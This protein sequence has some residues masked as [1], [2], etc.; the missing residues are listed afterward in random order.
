MSALAFAPA[1]LPLRD[2]TPLP[3]RDCTPRRSRALSHAPARMVVAAPQASRPKAAASRAAAPNR[4]RST[5]LDDNHLYSYLRDIGTI[6]LLSDDEVATCSAHIANLSRWERVKEQLD[7]TAA[8]HTQK[9]RLLTSRYR[10]QSKPVPAATVSTADWADALQ[11]DRTVFAAALREARFYKDR[12]VAA[13]LRLVVSIAKKYQGSGVGLT[14]LIQEGSLGLIRAAEKFDAQR[15]FKFTT[16]ASWWI[17]QAVQRAVADSSRAIRLPTHV[18]DAAKKARRLANQFEREHNYPP[19]M[20][21]LA[22]IMGIREE[23]LSFILSKA[24]Q[25][26][27][28][29]L[30]CPLYPGSNSSRPVSLGDS[31][32]ANGSSPEEEVSRGLLRE[33]VENVLLMLSPKEREVLR[34]RYG[35]D[36]G[37]TKNFDEIGKMYSV[38]AS[39]IR[40]IEAR[41]MRKL[42]HPNF[43]R[44]LSEWSQT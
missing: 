44:C 40:Q 32:A 25:T 34:M 2:C 24:E 4:P 43:H 20:D 11:M 39:R 6:S 5:G 42:R 17:R 38:P 13:N 15:G 8:R 35:F 22:E 36:D 19:R 26:D 37:R 9:R 21:Q 16:Y 29:S 41:A 30:D 14:D 18:A 10:R 28:L 27:T 1:P 33:D 3:L 31:L 7:A 12:L 23:R